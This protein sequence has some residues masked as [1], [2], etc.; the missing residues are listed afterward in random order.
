MTNSFEDPCVLG[1]VV[2]AVFCVRLLERRES[3]R[4][5]TPIMQRLRIVERL[6]GSKG[7]PWPSTVKKVNP[8]SAIMQISDSEKRIVSDLNRK[9]VVMWS[10]VFLRVCSFV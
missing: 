8:L 7:R 4:T 9:R 10:T 5:L 2:P 1:L 3:C 6:P